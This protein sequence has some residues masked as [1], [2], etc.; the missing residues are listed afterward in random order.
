MHDFGYGVRSYPDDGLN[1]VHHKDIVKTLPPRFCVTD[2]FVIADGV[3]L[4]IKIVRQIPFFIKV[5]FRKSDHFARKF[6]V[7]LFRCGIQ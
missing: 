3:F 7:R 4:P 5:I 6:P 1:I 2:I